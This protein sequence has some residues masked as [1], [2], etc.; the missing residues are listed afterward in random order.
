MLT[1]LCGCGMAVAQNDDGQEKRFYVTESQFFSSSV[2]NEGQAIIYSD[3]NQPY[4]IWTPQTGEI[5]EIGGISA[6][7]GIGGVGSFSDNGTKISA[8]MQSDEIAVSTK[9]AK[10]QIV[11]FDG[12]IKEIS[13]IPDASKLYAVGSS[14]DGQKG[15]LLEESNNGQVWRESA[16]TIYDKD[17][18]E[19]DGWEGGLEFVTGQS[20]YRAYTGGQNGCFYYTRRDGAYWEA[21]DP[22]PADNTDEVK[23]YWTMNFIPSAEYAGIAQYG[24]LGLELA[25]GTGAIWYTTDAVE[26]FN[27][28]SGVGGVPVYITS[29]GEK[30]FMVTRNGLIQKSEDYGATWTTVLNTGA[31]P[32]PW[33]D[34]DAPLFNRIRFADEQNGMALGTG[35]VYTTTDGGA[36]WAQHT[37]ADGTENIAWNDVAF[38]NG[39]ATVVGSDGNA[40]ETADMG[41]TWTKITVDDG[42]ATDFYGIYVNDEAYVLC[43][44]DASLFY[45]GA[46]ENVSGYTAAVYD[47]ETETWTPLASTGYFSGDAA[48]SGYDISGD[49][50]TV[51]GGVYNY[52]QLNENSAVRCDAAAWVNGELVIL[53]NKFA[54]IN[55]NSQARGVSYDG[56]VIVGWQDQC[57]PWYAS[58][59]R[60]NASGSYDQ[61]LMFKD[62]NMTDDDVNWDD[63]N[64]KTSKLLGQA[65]AVSADGKIIG[66]RGLGDW[67]ATDCAWLWSEENGLQ[68]LGGTSN[69]VFD[70]TNDGSFVVTNSEVWT[71][72]TGLVGVNE[73]L[74]NNLGI[75][76]GEYGIMG[77]YDISPNGRYMTGWCMKGDNKY[78]YVV[79]LKGN[80]PSS[81]ERELE[82]TKAAVYPNP[83]SEE[84]HVDL[85]FEGIKTRISLYSLQGGC[86]KAVTTTAMTN[87][88][89]VSDVP[90]GLYILDV[91]ANGTH[92]S[93]KLTVKH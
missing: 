23:T 31:S 50:T 70:M 22:H 25:D 51:I 93:F 7:N 75:D 90:T 73:Y 83:A 88:I 4:N 20:V 38:L 13:K 36:T 55:R 19:L 12:Y 89:N 43:G 84:L 85:P 58:V 79:D 45:K 87:V 29:V 11:G 82:Q 18:N 40:Y 5:K 65:E 2:N 86:V 14:D 49:G 56:S 92:K 46:S 91:N 48:S 62:P 53:G 78:A 28:A 57:G 64:D 71:E 9:W 10:T 35:V 81:I 39:T 52:E 41:Q 26:S 59:W 32:S 54:D 72:E 80:T 67:Y 77:I 17:Y 69:Q 1:G 3:Q 44:S 42:A 60:K 27:E 63:F 68:L 8:V 24:V 76:L 34:G 30:Y 47:T 74:T 16:T 37:V 66:G 21:V 6:G 33:A 61:S 15:V